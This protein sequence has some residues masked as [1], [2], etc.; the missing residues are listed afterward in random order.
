MARVAVIGEE[1]RVQGLRLAG[2]IVCPAADPAAA[3]QA[4]RALPADVA[5]VVVTAASAAWLRDELARRPDMLPV[6]MPTVPP[7]VMPS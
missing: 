2:A 3:R 5:V 6:M 4:L 1:L 7:G